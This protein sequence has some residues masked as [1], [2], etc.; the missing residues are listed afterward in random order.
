MSRGFE[1]HNTGDRNPTQGKLAEHPQEGQGIIIGGYEL[2][3]TLAGLQATQQ[4]IISRLKALEDKND[5]KTRPPILGLAV[6][7]LEPGQD[8]VQ[9][10]MTPRITS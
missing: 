7:D 2:G 1:G 3:M 8:N 4:I 9:T 5:N 6:T 10:R